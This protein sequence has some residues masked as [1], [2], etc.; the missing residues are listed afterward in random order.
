MRS[1]A[2]DQRVEV[3]VEDNPFPVYDRKTVRDRARVMGE[4]FGD[5][6]TASPA[7]H[8]FGYS[9]RMPAERIT[10]AQLVR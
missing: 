5:V 7:A 3:A 1:S 6:Q 9:A 4:G 10:P 8:I 2:A